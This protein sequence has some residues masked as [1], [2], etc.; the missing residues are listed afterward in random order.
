MNN[1]HNNGI[2]YSRHIISLI[3]VAI[4]AGGGAYQLN[5]IKHERAE[6]REVN[7][8]PHSSDLEK[9]NSTYETIVSDYVGDIDKKALIDGAIKGMTTALDDPYSDYFSGDDADSLNATID[10]SFE[11]I[12]ATMSLENEQPVIAEK[13]MKNSPAENADLKI[14]DIVTK[15]DGKETK[16]RSLDEVVETIKGKK[17]TDVTLTILRGDESF[18]VTLTR[19]EIALETVKGT[20]DE[21]DKT[22]GNIIVKSFTK[23]TA[24]EF[25]EAIESLRKEGATSFIVDVRNNPGGLLDQVATMASMFLKNG[26]TIVSFEDKDENK[27]ELVAGKELDGGFKIKEPTVVLVNGSSASASEIFAAALN[28]SAKIPVVGSKTFGKGTVQTVN[29]LENNTDLKLT[30]SKWLTPKGEWIHEKGF[31]P[32]VKVELPAFYE[33]KSIDRNETYEE[34]AKGTAIQ[35]LNLVLSGIDDSVTADSDTYTV[36]T[37]AAVKKV[38]ESE[39][40]SVTGIVDEATASAIE[41][42]LIAKITAKDLPYEKALEEVKKGK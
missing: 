41:L 11:G 8:Y 17:G 2:P 5:E 26:K 21:T 32:S 14:G 12:G 27:Q 9:I 29:S 4:I 25:K 6:L 16:G 7:R 3:C 40:L 42:K 13:P 38:Q 18:D 34:G 19:D 31:E 20:L 35:N 36:D 10:G 15:V 37:I 33:S 1:K 28:E 23:H 39:K 24:D 30:T 22:V